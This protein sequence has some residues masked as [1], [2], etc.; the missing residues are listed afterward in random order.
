MDPPELNPYATIGIETT[1]PRTTQ[2]ARDSVRFATQK[3]IFLLKNTG[4]LLPLDRTILKSLGIIGPHRPYPSA[5]P[6]QSYHR[7]EKP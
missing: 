5:V 2:K 4:N 6:S 3:S 7:L 1:D